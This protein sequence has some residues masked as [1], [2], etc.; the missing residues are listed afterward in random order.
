M[1]KNYLTF[2]IGKKRIGVPKSENLILEPTLI[3]KLFTDESGTEYIMYRRQNVPVYDTSDILFGERMKKFDGLVFASMGE[4]TIAIKT[5][6]F[7]D[8][9]IE[10]DVEFDVRE[11][12]ISS[13]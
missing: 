5:E 3:N 10:F 6:S 4:A 7:F 11:L 2:K 9:E 8:E 1:K 13:S 12:F